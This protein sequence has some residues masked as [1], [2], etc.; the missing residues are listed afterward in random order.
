M[1][2]FF[3]NEVRR[4][5]MGMNIS[6]EV[7]NLIRT[8]DENADGKKLNVLEH[9]AIPFKYQHCFFTVMGTRYFFFFKM[10]SGRVTEYVLEKIMPDGVT[11]K[12]IAASDKDLLGGGYYFPQLP[13]AADAERNGVSK[14][15]SSWIF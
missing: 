14:R 1:S 4:V 9:P 7:R 12:L 11:I 13:N 6:S 8:I 3:E 15:V 10:E 5:S 2:M